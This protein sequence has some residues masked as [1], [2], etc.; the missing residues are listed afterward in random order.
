MKSK[1]FGKYISAAVRSHVVT[2]SNYI[3]CQSDTLMNGPYGKKRLLR[4]S[5]CGELPT[6]KCVSKEKQSRSQSDRKTVQIFVY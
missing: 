3:F 6:M 1:L 4:S 2:D 5:S